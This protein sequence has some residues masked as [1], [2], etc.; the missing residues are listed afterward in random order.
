MGIKVNYSKYC[1]WRKNTRWRLKGVFKEE[2][3]QPVQDLET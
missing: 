3:N 1:S 2:N